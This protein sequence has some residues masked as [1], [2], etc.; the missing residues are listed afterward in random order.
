LAA[1]IVTFVSLFFIAAP[2]GRHNRK[3]WGPQVDNKMGW[4]IMELV[5]PAALSVF[6][7]YGMGEKNQAV[8]MFYI[9]WVFHYLYRSIYFPLKLNTTGKTIPL[10]IVLMAIFFNSVNGGTNGYFFGNFAQLYQD[11]SFSSLQFI[12]GITLFVAGF[13]IHFRSDHILIGL[14]KRNKE[15][16]IPSRFL[17]KYVASPNYLGEM[18]EWLGFAIM[19]NALSAWCFWAWTVANLFPRALANYK[20]YQNKFENYPK[21]R[22]A[23]IPFVY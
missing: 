20:W 23:L 4:I 11:Y 13:F 19:T 17:F 5:S 21:N 1:A 8:W 3:G 9:L 16:V 2:Y 10:S 15:Y 12:L 22:K 7:F 18:L 14:R 6:F